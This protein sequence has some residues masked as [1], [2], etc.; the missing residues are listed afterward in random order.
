VFWL[1]VLQFH[2]LVKQQT[3]QKTTKTEQADKHTQGN[4]NNNEGKNKW[5]HAECDHVKKRQKKA[6]TFK[7]MKLKHPTHL[8]MAM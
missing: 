5:K 8:R 1:V 2:R 3:K 4:I 6:E 7:H